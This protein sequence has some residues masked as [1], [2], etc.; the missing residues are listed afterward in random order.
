MDPWG[1]GAHSFP[2][3]Q[4]I[5]DHISTIYLVFR[6][7]VLSGFKLI[8]GQWDPYFF[9][10]KKSQLMSWSSHG[11]TT[12]TACCRRKFSASASTNRKASVDVT[13]GC[14]VHL[15]RY[16]GLFL[17]GILVLPE[18]PRD[19]RLSVAN[20]V[21]NRISSY[22]EMLMWY[23]WSWWESCWFIVRTND[24]LSKASWSDP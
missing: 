6:M 4:K 22:M 2:W 11:D 9:S 8:T 21:Y 20:F 18:R 24:G 1:Q 3:L 15:E 14:W 7:K 5:A 17:F 23:K 13:G 19:L 12:T 10:T 16:P